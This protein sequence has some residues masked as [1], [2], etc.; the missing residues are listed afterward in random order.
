M[1]PFDWTAIWMGLAAGSAMSALF[2]AGLG[3]GL[4]LALRRAHPVGLL[5]LSAVL[6]MATLLGAGWLVVAQWG[7]WSLM[8]YGAAFLITRF[9]ETTIARA[10]APVGPAL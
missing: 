7:P 1:T 3:L 6:R 8:G 5:M 4:R 2:F 10:G 9:V